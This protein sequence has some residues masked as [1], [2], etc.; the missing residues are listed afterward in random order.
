MLRERE[1]KEYFQQDGTV[2]EWWDPEN[3]DMAHIFAREMNIVSSWLAEPKGQKVLDIS[4]G[5]GRALKRLSP[6][7]SLT[8]LDIS[9]EMLSQ[10]ASLN[11]AR[12]DLIQA[13]AEKL[14]FK[15]NS[16]DSILRLLNSYYTQK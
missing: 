7:H 6:N 8:G 13:D 9:Q 1:V 10:V 5:K 15:I 3:S 14:P 2:I 11:L 12:T 16:Y 4:C